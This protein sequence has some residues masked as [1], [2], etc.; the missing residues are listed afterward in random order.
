MSLC[1]R[2]AVAPGPVDPSKGG[3]AEVEAAAADELVPLLEYA[4]LLEEVGAGKTA[5]VEHLRHS[6][7]VINSAVAIDESHT[8]RKK[9]KRMLRSV[10][11]Y[12]RDEANSQAAGPTD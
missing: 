8:A 4:V 7:I 2:P 5:E 12:S 11:T 1:E 3:R 9:K 6:V 10:M